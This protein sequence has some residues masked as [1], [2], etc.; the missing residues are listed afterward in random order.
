MDYNKAVT[1]SQ[2]EVIKTSKT[3]MLQ[4]VA[5]LPAN[6][7][8]KTARDGEHSARRHARTHSWKPEY[9]LLVNNRLSGPGSD[10]DVGI[11]GLQDA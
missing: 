9:D 5:F 7:A 2:C 6:K 8:K 1:S 4:Q 3:T 11:A 10:L